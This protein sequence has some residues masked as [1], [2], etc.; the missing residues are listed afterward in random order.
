MGELNRQ[1]IRR[2]QLVDCRLEVVAQLEGLR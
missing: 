1:D 2:Q